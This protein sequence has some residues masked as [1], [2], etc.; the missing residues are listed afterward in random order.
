MFS[1]TQADCMSWWPGANSQCAICWLGLSPTRADSSKSA[2]FSIKPNL[3]GEGCKYPNFLFFLSKEDIFLSRMTPRELRYELSH[4]PFYS[5]EKGHFFRKNIIW[6][7][8]VILLN[9]LHS[10]FGA[11]YIIS[12]GS[13]GFTK[14]KRLKWCMTDEAE[15]SDSRTAR[16]RLKSS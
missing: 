3:V 10:L 4:S 8:G 15:A 7:S 5:V 2:L 6:E 1:E 9:R 12:K 16:L 14:K 11:S 13:F